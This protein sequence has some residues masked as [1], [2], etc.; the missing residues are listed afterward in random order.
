M[1]IVFDPST[2][3][4]SKKGSVTGVVFFDFGAARQ[5]PGSGWNDFVIVILN[6]WLAALERLIQGQPKADLRFMDGPYW[7]TAIAHGPSLLLRCIEDRTDAGPPYD[8]LVRVED[9]KRELMT[10]ARQLSNA[11][12]QAHIQSAELNELRKY[13]AN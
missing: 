6:W 8:V 4:Q 1:R 12:A 5:F 10:F 7:I 2:L 11:C 9:L 13:L 3:R